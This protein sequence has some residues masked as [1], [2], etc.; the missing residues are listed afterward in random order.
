VL[1]LFLLILFKR[2]SEGEFQ[3]GSYRKEA[4]DL[5]SVVLYFSKQKYDIIALIGHSKGGNAVLL[6]ASK[7]NDVPIIVNISG[8]F[9][10]ERGID[11]R[12]GRNFMQRINKDGYIDVKNKKGI[13]F[14]Y[15]ILYSFS[16]NAIT[17]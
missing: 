8:R 2:E 4:A 1:Y 16:A 5:R 12:L 10:L 3:Y 15:V 9:A 13:S 7:Y 17:L 6:Y 14:L 11:G